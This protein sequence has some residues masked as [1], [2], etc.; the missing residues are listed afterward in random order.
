MCGVRA[1]TGPGVAQGQRIGA[2][3]CDRRGTVAIVYR[4]GVWLGGIVRRNVRADLDIGVGIDVAG[5]ELR[6][7][8][9]GDG[10]ANSQLGEGGGRCLGQ[11]CVYFGEGGVGG[12]GADEVAGGRADGP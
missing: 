4:V 1:G 10:R 7:R 8:Y 5:G 3:G 12:N 6:Q 9:A 11:D 2:A